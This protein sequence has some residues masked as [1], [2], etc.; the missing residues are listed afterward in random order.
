MENH[1]KELTDEEVVLIVRSKDK[2]LYSLI[3]ERYESKLF[4]YILNMVKD[5][6]KATDI[7]QESFIKAFTNLNGF[8]TNKKFSSWIYRIAHNESLNAIKK[9]GKEITMDE[10]FDFQSDENIEK[11]FEKNEVSLMV[12]DC[13]DKIPVKYSEPLSLFY[14]EEKSYEEISEILRLPMGTVA[15]RIN[16]AKILM[17]KICRI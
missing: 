2:N 14:I 10:D 8:D 1:L 16:R 12:N 5:H 3:I 4:R 11:D 9:Y 15:T 13:L 17:K 6:D 7:L